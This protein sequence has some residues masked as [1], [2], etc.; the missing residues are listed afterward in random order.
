MAILVFFLLALSGSNAM[1]QQPARPGPGC[2]GGGAEAERLHYLAADYS[3]GKGGL[4]YDPEKSA[5]LYKEAIELGS[6]RSAV[7]L[8]ILYRMMYV[9][10]PNEQ[11]MLQEMNRL[12]QQAIDMGCSDAYLHL[13]YSYQ[14]GWGVEESEQKMR[15]IIQ[16]G[17][18]EGSFACMSGLAQ[19]LVSEDK[20]EEAKAW[21][22]R[23][24][25][26]GYGPAVEPYRL[27]FFGEGDLEKEV[28]VQRQGARLGNHNSLMQLSYLYEDGERQP[29][30]L[31]YAA[32]F[33]GIADEIDTSH[34][35]PMIDDL[36]E[37]C[38]P[39]PV[40]P[41]AKPAK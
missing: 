31:E 26:G 12:F 23:A 22:Q 39:R 6:A 1:A 37:R 18:E 2:S 28:E 17:V 21:F 15:E 13:A 29:K 16:K 35:P 30:D 7:N 32:C 38:P 24:L 19:I 10:E 11:E 3:S 36:D 41:H 40:V 20:R 34:A 9:M 27:L 25:D 33:K 4:P 14:Q 5:R 8:G